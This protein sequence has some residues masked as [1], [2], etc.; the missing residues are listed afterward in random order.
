MLFDQDDRPIADDEH[1][2]VPPDRQ[3]RV[4]RWLVVLAALVVLGLVALGGAGLWVRG[5][6]DPAG[7][8]GEE[9]AFEIPRGSTTS[10]IADQ[11]AE[12]GI[13][14]SGEVFRWYLRYKGGETF[15]AG[16]YRLRRNSAMWDVVAALKAGP[17]LPPAVNLTIPEGLWVVEVAERIDR[18]DHLSGAAFLE[19]AQSGTVRSQFQPEGIATLEGL[20]FPETYRIQDD[21]DEEDVLRRLVATFDRVATDVGYADAPARVGVSPYEAII[22]ASLIEAE[23]K[24]DEDRAKIARV[25][26]NRLE[27]GIPLGIDATFYFH[28]GPD[29]K[30]TSLR[31]SDLEAD[32]PYNTRLHAGLVPTAIAIPGRAS[33][34]AA[35]NPEPGPW[36]YYVLADESGVH[37]FSESYDEFLRNKAEAQRRGLIP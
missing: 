2:V 23:A 30:G 3:R 36:L 15:A 37:A 33:L 12:A 17:A 16:Q 29:R 1:E 27:Q 28:L 26:Y 7:P 25:I 13:I 21:E 22:V 10:E 5:Q 14:S 20:L 31:V 6:L 19:L 32:H 11:L 18:V 24:V 9:I 8:P 35:L 34:E 4:A